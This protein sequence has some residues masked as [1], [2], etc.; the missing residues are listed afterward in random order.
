MLTHRQ[1]TLL[2]TTDGSPLRGANGQFL[3]GAVNLCDECGQPAPEP[4]R[5]LRADIE[6]IVRELRPVVAPSAVHLPIHQ[7]EPVGEHLTLRELTTYSRRSERWL[8]DRTKDVNDPLPCAKPHG[9]KLTFRRSGYDA[10]IARRQ[11]MCSRSVSGV[12]DDVL[13]QIR[14]R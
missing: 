9:G 10:W 7:L 6:A 11:E 5:H 3:F 12:V 2:W 1:G 4:H 13:S 8:R 14:G